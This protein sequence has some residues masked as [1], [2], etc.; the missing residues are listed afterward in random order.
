MEPPSK[1]ALAVVGAKESITDAAEDPVVSVMDTSP[2]PKSRDSEKYKSNFVLAGELSHAPFAGEYG[3]LV[4]AVEDWIENGVPPE[5]E[6]V[7]VDSVVKENV[8]WVF[9]YTSVVED[10]RY[11]LKQLLGTV[12]VIVPPPLSPPVLLMGTSTTLLNHFAVGL[13]HAIETL[14]AS[15]LVAPLAVSPTVTETAFDDFC[16]VSENV[17]MIEK[18]LTGTIVAE[19][20]FPASDSCA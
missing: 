1:V 12:V 20:I 11:A 8:A 17:R 16:T 15:S 14:L 6:Q 2:S 3:M 9:M 13:L 7:L 5:M 10:A 18:S 19:G 4:F